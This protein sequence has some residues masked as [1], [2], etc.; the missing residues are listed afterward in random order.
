M[1]ELSITPAGLLI[2]F[3]ALVVLVALVVA[4]RAW[5]PRRRVD[6][7]DGPVIDLT[8][9]ERAIKSD[10]EAARRRREEHKPLLSQ[11]PSADPDR[12]HRLPR[13]ER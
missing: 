13:D 3:F 10:E 1:S 5:S 4:A 7:D 11:A 12:A 6:D 9:L 2:A 8:Y